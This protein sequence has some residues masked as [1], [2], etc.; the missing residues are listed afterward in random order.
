MTIKADV[1]IVGAG[2]AGIAAAVT[3]AKMGLKT[4]LLEKETFPGGIPVKGYISTFCGLYIDDSEN[5]G[6]RMLYD[7][8]A[9]EFALFLM[10]LDRIER[11][12]RMGRAH[13]LP[14]RPENFAVT[15]HSL[16]EREPALTVYYETPFSSAEVTAGRI[17]SL[18]AHSHGYTR[19]FEAAAVIDASGEAAVG[20]AAG[21]FLILPD[22]ERQVPALIFPLHHVPG[23]E[24][25]VFDTTRRQVIIRR[26]VERGILPREAECAGFQSMPDPDVLSVKMNLGALVKAESSMSEKRLT[27]R[28]NELKRIFIRFLREHMDGFEKCTTPDAISPVLCRESVRIQGPRL[29]TERDVLSGKR[30]PDAI[31]KGCWPVE[32]WHDN[33][34]C[35]VRYLPAGEFYEIPEGALRSSGIGNLFMAG[36]CIS[37]DAGAIASARV[38]GCCMA[39]GEAAANLAAQYIGRA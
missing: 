16:L 20:R 1:V 17:R 7:G 25:S 13:V 4:V 28:A 34:I 32:E 36:K 24:V 9:R 8:F 22:G 19:R 39:T 6:V 14:Y 2:P 3:S 10:H 27:Y 29:L 11:P 30:F 31:A 12:V 5:G 37:A 35:A 38:I 33:G 15:V 26:A 18:E 23:G 21:D